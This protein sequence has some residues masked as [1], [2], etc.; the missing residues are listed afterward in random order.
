MFR[1]RG[2]L[3]NNIKNENDGMKMHFRMPFY[4]FYRNYDYTI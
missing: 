1:D 3:P 4:E 2:E